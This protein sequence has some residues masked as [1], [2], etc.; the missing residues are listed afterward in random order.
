MENK[1]KNPI[2]KEATNL[3]KFQKMLIVGIIA[4]SVMTFVGL[5]RLLF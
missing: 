1:S 5:Y 3:S 4:F 2:K